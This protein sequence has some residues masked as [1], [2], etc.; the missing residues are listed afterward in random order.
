MSKT[1]EEYIPAL[2][3]RFL[4]PFYDFVQKYIVRDVRYKSLLVAQANIQPGQQVLDLGC[5]TGTLAIMAKQAQPG[6]EV[7]GLDADPDMLKV[8]KYKAGLLRA[9][10]NFDTGFTNHLP[11]P[12]ESFD[13]ILSSIMIHHLKTPHKIQTAQEVYRVLKPGGQLHI[14]DFGKP[15]SWYGKILGPFLHKFEE[16][17]DNIEGTLPE[18]FG[19]P[20]L[21][22]Q[23]TGNFWTFFGD[24]AFLRGEK[25]GK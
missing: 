17:N 1:N 20:G 16:A 15:V 6:A 7:A 8:A 23:V 5:G 14:I 22:T 2:S 25:P 11:Y 3:Y 24:L 9:L 21:K 19:A 13:R 18:I 10:V 4:T 12:D